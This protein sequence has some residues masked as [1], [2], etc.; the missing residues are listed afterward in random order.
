MKKV[1]R[2]GEEGEEEGEG[3]VSLHERRG[4]SYVWKKL[5]L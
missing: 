2:R 4:L 3:H 1:R 5:A